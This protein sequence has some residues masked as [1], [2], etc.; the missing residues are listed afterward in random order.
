MFESKN[1][2]SVYNGARI[3]CE[4]YFFTLEG[5]LLLIFIQKYC[6]I[7][8]TFKIGDSLGITFLLLRGQYCAILIIDKIF[9]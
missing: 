3:D 8:V 6:Y 9:L 2:D 1:H 4:R 5:V 7:Y